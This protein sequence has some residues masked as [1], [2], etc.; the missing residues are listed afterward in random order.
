MLEALQQTGIPANVIHPCDTQASLFKYSW[1][2]QVFVPYAIAELKK[3]G[4]I[5]MRNNISDCEDI[6]MA[7]RHYAVRLH[8][9]D[10]RDSAAEDPSGVNATGNAVGFLFIPGHAINAIITSDAPEE[11]TVRFLDFTLGGEEI[12][13]DKEKLDKCKLAVI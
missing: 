7:V 9:R 4:L 12:N 2:R 6:A 13:P 11:S 10:P 3:D 8:R 1:V 5:P